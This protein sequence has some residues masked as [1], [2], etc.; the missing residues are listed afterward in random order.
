VER[1]PS[2]IEIVQKDKDRGFRIGNK[3]KGIW[4]RYQERKEGEEFNWL[5]LKGNAASNFIAHNINV[6]KWW[7]DPQIK[8]E[9][10]KTTGKKLTDYI[11]SNEQSTK[12]QIEKRK[13]KDPARVMSTIKRVLMQINQETRDKHTENEHLITRFK[14]YLSIEALKLEAPI[15]SMKHLKRLWKQ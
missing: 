10:W 4:T 6:G 12:E 3:P 2:A 5:E 1:E 9:D 8:K 7:N 15:G 13:I 14:G 11:L